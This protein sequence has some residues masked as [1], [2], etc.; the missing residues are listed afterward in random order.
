MN[1]TACR[2]PCPCAL[3]QRIIVLRPPAGPPSAAAL[4]AAHPTNERAA[5][6]ILS[7]AAA[8]LAEL[9]D[10]VRGA[11]AAG[12][13]PELRTVE[14][15]AGAAAAV[16]LGP[17]TPLHAPLA[18]GLQSAEAPSG[19]GAPSR[20]RLV[21]F[22]VGVV[23]LGKT[24]LALALRDWLLARGPPAPPTAAAAAP[25]AAALDQ[26]EF[27]ALG[28]EGAKAAVLARLHALLDAG[29][30]VVL[31]HRNG[32]GSGPLLQALRA[33]AV[34]WAVLGPAELLPPPPGEGVAGSRRLPAAVLSV[35]RSLATRAAQAD[36]GAPVPASDPAPPPMH[37]LIG[38]PL[39][40]QVRRCAVL[41]P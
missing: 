41:H 26:D 16:T 1:P 35:A 32:P 37:P 24:T 5:A 23:G 14:D 22:V 15:A 19:S 10:A 12:G 7:R 28:K 3:L 33:R 38:M 40:R 9:E 2:C 4:T 6:A 25:F 29:V 21:V 31:L 17:R 30:G 18:P 11:P 27:H 13:A 36:A 39:A 34:R 20:T 8:Q